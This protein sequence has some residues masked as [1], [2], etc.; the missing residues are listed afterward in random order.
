M[1]LAPSPFAGMSRPEPQDFPSGTYSLGGHGLCAT[2]K[3]SATG[4]D[5]RP[6]AQGRCALS[7]LR[8]NTCQCWSCRGLSRNPVEPDR[9]RPTRP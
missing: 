6:A 2:V 1:T 5:Q 3:D 9:R 8:A 4:I 7:K